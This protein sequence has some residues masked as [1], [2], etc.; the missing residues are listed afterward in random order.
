MT[1]IISYAQNFEDVILWRA[2][3]HVERGFYIDIGA[4]DPVVDSVSL[5]F[6][7][8]GWR[9]VHVEPVTQFAQ[10]L[11][12]ARPD[13]QVIEAAISSSEAR[14]QLFEITD[15]GLSTGSETIARDHVAK[16]FSMHPID[17]ASMRL[18]QLL[19][20]H[21]D[22]PIHWLK[23]DV[24]GMECDVIESWAPSSVRPW[25]V[26]VESTK[27]NSQEASYADWELKLLALDYEFVYFDGL[28]RFYVSCGH[29]DLKPSFGPG[30]NFFD[31]FVLSG[32]ANA[33]FCKKLNDDRAVLERKLAG[34]LDEVARLSRDVEAAQAEADH[35]TNDQQAR[36]KALEQKIN[37][38]TDAL[39]RNSKE[40]QAI[41]ASRLWRFVQFL[42]KLCKY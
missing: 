15:T 18:S 24:E 31:D 41:E 36:R 34:L 26:V 2:L 28:N 3:K 7:E 29:L 16:G 4:Q 23:I 10:K 12:S 25:I 1:T 35:I 20:S 27:P 22:Q 33:P 8:Q 5:A 17:V 40:L 37:D 42:R 21:C 14:M 19:D 39:A 32:L 38:L 30:P 9:G 13:E 11:R 6:Y